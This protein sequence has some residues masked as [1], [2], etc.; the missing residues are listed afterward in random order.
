M[1]V[2]KSLDKVRERIDQ[3]DND[4][5]QLINLRAELAITVGKVKKSTDDKPVFYR[6]EREAE[7]LQ[8]IIN[9]NNGPLSDNQISIIFRDLMT[10]CLYLQQPITIAFLGPEGTYTQMAVRKHFGVETKTHAEPTIGR[11]FREVEAEH[12]SYGVVPIEN[13]TAGV[14]NA[15]LDSLI[16]S[17]LVICGEIIL[18]IHH[19]LLCAAESSGD[20]KRIYAHDQA[21]QQCGRWLDEH[22]AR[23]ETIAVSSNGIAAQLAV[24]ELDAAAIAGD[25]AVDLYSLK[26][27]YSN[28]E[29]NPHNETRFIILG[30]QKVGATGSDK[31]TFIIATPHKPGALYELL[32]TFAEYNINI[33][34]IA[35]RPY[36]GRGWSYIFFLDVE[37]HRD[38]KSIK[39][40][41]EKLETK[42]IML[43]ILGSYPKAVI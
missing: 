17:P 5:Q 3:I 12:V 7:V 39:L 32:Q 18:P 8:K 42:S 26:R 2:D 35:S 22:M 28:I 34:Q 36:G 33:T 15:T 27:L 41:L 4:I 11:V 1:S 23:V 16:D 20:I 37:G 6:P 31:T 40:A 21:L 29:D 19:H 43:N 9:R 24:K 25:L 13:S 30:R 14:I 10:A 38:D